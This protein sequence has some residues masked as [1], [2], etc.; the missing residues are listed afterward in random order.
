MS[1]F[2]RIRDW[3]RPAPKLSPAEAQKVLTAAYRQMVDEASGVPDV[4]HGEAGFVPVSYYDKTACTETEIG[5][6]AYFG[7]APRDP[8][9]ELIEK[10]GLPELAARAFAEDLLGQVTEAIIECDPSPKAILHE[11]YRTVMNYVDCKLHGRED[12]L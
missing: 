5:N 7:A 2:N 10:H 3:F 9:Q 6:A 8:I 1:L 11:P 4:M 12:L